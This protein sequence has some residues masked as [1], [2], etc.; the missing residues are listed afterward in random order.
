MTRLWSG[1]WC[2]LAL[3]GCGGS[4]PPPGPTTPS[5]ARTPQAPELEDRGST[6]EPHDGRR[7]PATREER[8]VL[9]RLAN[10]AESVRLLRFQVPIE[11][12]IEDDVAIAG[13]LREQID[14]EELERAH[15]LYGALG[16]LDPKADLEEMF[17][18]V[19]G[20]QVIGYYDPK[21]SRLVIREDIIHGLRGRLGPNDAEEARLVL[22]HE[23]VHA[24]QDQRLGL[25]ESYDVDRTADADNAFRAV[26]EGDA[27]LAMLGNTLRAQGIPLSAATQ[28]IQQMGNLVNANA[29]VQGEKLD[30]APAIIRVTLVAPYLRGLQFIAAVYSVGGWPSVNRAHRR[31]PVSTEQIL[32]PD[33]YFEGEP[34]EAFE[35]A[36]ISV[37]DAAGFERIAEDTL[38]ELELAVYLGQ[39]QAGDVD[40]A[41]AAGWAGDHLALYTRGDRA[42][43]VWWTTWDTEEDAIVA[44]RAAARVSPENNGSW[45]LRDGRALLIVRGLPPRHRTPVRRSFERFARDING[46]PPP[47][48]RRTQLRN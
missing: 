14:A 40:E 6:A 29:F 2:W 45:V 26:I 25:A 3:A 16:L 39:G 19:L 9:E 1:L 18:A 33:K 23:L 15:L 20:E 36:P 27:T 10:A 42:A 37:L 30:D 47:P 32:H 28:G 8:D 44:E 13:S 7:R 48:E 41:A 17:A 46:T 38:G 31:P 11:I 34:A 5:I 12:E 21:E 22:V 4:Q 35:V 43:V 24:L